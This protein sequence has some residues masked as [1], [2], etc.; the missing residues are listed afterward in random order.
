MI[1]A[2]RESKHRAKSIL[3]V[4]CDSSFEISLSNSP[5]HR[6][7]SAQCTANSDLREFHTIY[8]YDG[9]VR[10]KK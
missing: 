3:V 5:E 10:A 7:H 6:V 8:W 4:F 1:S 9:F 2:N